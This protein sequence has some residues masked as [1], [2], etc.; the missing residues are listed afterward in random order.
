MILDRPGGMKKLLKLAR[1]GYIQTHSEIDP[2][3]TRICHHFS[4]K[5]FFSLGGQ[6]KINVN[7]FEFFFSKNFFSKGP[8]KFLM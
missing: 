1:K 2:N 5:H 3:G 7:L 4:Q 8:K 6:K